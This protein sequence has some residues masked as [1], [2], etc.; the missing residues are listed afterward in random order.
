MRS[1]IF[2][3]YMNMTSETT[4]AENTRR[5]GTTSGE[6]GTLPRLPS[7][8]KTHENAFL[9]T[10]CRRGRPGAAPAPIAR[11]PQRTV[12]GGGRKGWSP[13]TASKKPKYADTAK[14]F[15]KHAGKL[16]WT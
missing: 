10:G 11:G 13:H 9:R 14:A 4:A 1:P 8:T 15:S 2:S 7:A 16:K 12:Q 5:S 3:S 6:R